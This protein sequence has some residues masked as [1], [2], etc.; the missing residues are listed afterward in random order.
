MDMKKKPSFIERMKEA[1]GQKGKPNNG[2]FTE[3][4]IRSVLV[5]AK[6]CLG[7]RL[8]AASMQLQLEATKLNGYLEIMESDE[9]QIVQEL[10]EKVVEVRA[11][12]LMT[13]LLK[14]L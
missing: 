12:K 6:L 14:K 10:A 5:K 8:S 2:T 3:E 4:E 9:Q 1:V 11:L 13:L 7:N